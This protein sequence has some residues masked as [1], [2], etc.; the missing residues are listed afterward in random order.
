MSHIPD[1]KVLDSESVGVGWLDPN[2]PYNQGPVPPEFAARL[3][4]FADHWFDSIKAL[5]YGVKMGYHTCGFCSKAHGS[6]TFG[7]PAGNTLYFCPEL[8]AHYVDQHSYAPPAEF[9]TA[10]L[11]CPL[12]GTPEYAAAVAPIVAKRTES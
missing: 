10:V 9:V 11:A 8:I 1:L 3:R 6:G 7:V 12:P 2:F 4:Q 5:K